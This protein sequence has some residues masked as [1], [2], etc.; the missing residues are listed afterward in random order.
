M[1]DIDEGLVL[2]LAL[3]GVLAVLGAVNT[4]RRHR[5]KRWLEH[6]PQFA[7]WLCSPQGDIT[8]SNATA[9]RLW[10]LVVDSVLT[11]P[12]ENINLWLKV[13]YPMHLVATAT[14]ARACWV[15]VTV[16]PENTGLRLCLEDITDS[17]LKDLQKTAQSRYWQTALNHFP[18]ALLLT[19]GNGRG[20]HAANRTACE[21]FGYP[22]EEIVH[23]GIAR[24]LPQPF[25]QQPDITFREYLYQSS[26]EET[27]P[28]PHQQIQKPLA[29]AVVLWTKEGAR[30]PVQLS[31][32]KADQSL[33]WFITPTHKE[34]LRQVS[35]QRF[36]RLLWNCHDEIFF[37]EASTL[38]ILQ[39]SQSATQNLGYSLEQLK[40]QTWLDLCPNVSIQELAQHTEQLKLQKAEVSIYRTQHRRENGSEYPV[41]V[42][43]S[44]SAEAPPVFLAIVNDIA[45]REA[46]ENRLHAM[47]HYDPLTG[48]PNRALLYDRLQ[49]AM[50]NV[51]RSGRL[52]AV[53]F[54]DLDKFKSINDDYGHETGDV[55]LKTVADRM[56]AIIRS[57][58]T[59]SRLAG[60]EFVL[61]GFNISSVEEA[62]ILGNK[63]LK[64]FDAP[65]EYQSFSRV[66]RPS[67]GITIYPLDDTD[68]EGLIRHSDEAMYRAKQEGRGRYCFYSWGESGI[69]NRLLELGRS[70]RE[71]LAMNQFKLQ[72]SPIVETATSEYYSEY[73][74]LLAGFYW[75]H[76][77]WHHVAYAD[78]MSAAARSGFSAE[79]DLWVVTQSCLR[80]QQIQQKRGEGLQLMIP[81]QGMSWR[82]DRFLDQIH[83]IF[84]RYQVP[85]HD[86][87]F[88]I[89]DQDWPEAAPLL[90]SKLR[91]LLNQ[92]LTLWLS[93]EKNGEKGTEK[94]PIQPAG[95]Q[96]L[97]LTHESLRWLD[98]TQP[99]LTLLPPEPAKTVLDWLENKHFKPWPR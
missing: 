62:A 63:I 84:S 92:G 15:R 86:I 75:D 16:F 91:P 79:M 58:D 94:P 78:A 33:I 88:L 74:G 50:A 97:C 72:F 12:F 66:I 51:I 71:S 87:T 10:P 77:E 34:S 26:D 70:I 73:Y 19:D 55:V 28:D 56:N 21:L 24:L 60:D 13:P 23:L 59:V 8:A 89:A 35:A 80:Y 81:L 39:A 47:A 90:K 7:Q 31:V 95:Y 44:Y 93:L 61:L 99:P 83:G 32:Q 11:L 4:L 41:E 1:N 64:A 46:L 5:Q 6:N 52:L 43:L 14:G 18:E 96:G 22:L 69:R 54:L 67:I 37:L 36:E 76:P 30:I 9:N 3:L 42:R 2:I 29:P 27:H 45:E 40:K 57:G 82:A 38:R 68:L 25:Y 85:A 65:I 53:A 20:V 49:Q 17:Q 48:L 98:A